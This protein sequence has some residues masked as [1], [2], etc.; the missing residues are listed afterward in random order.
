MATDSNCYAINPCLYLIG[1]SDATKSQYI[2][3]TLD[4][5]QWSEVSI[6]LKL[7]TESF[8][9]SSEKGMIETVCNGETETTYFNEGQGGATNYENCITVDT[10][11][12]DSLTLRVGGEIRY[13]CVC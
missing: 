11:N 8:D 6:G 7:R 2:E 10:S 13:A 9:D 12:C 5:S 4:S 1:K 3:R